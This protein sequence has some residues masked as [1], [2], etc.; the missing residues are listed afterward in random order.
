VRSTLFGLDKRAASMLIV[1]QMEP[2][3]FLDLL[4]AMQKKLASRV[5]SSISWLTRKPLALE[6]P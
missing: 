1:N 6:C 2:L 3:S 5:K 4:A